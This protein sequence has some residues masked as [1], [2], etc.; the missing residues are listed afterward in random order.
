[1]LQAA[2]GGTGWRLPELLSRVRE[3]DDLYFDAVSQ[4]RL[5]SW[6]TGRVT[7]LGDAAS[8]VSL[9]GEGSSLAMAGA[10]SLA[11]ALAAAPELDVALRR[12]EAEHRKLTGPKQR[13]G[14]Q[15]AAMLIPATRA[16]LAVRN[17]ATRLWPLAAA[18]SWT[19]RKLAREAA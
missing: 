5:P 16:G 7:L 3:A 10:Y 14:S 4:I 13:L 1:L 12:Y 19:G 8:C 15:A 6:S 17:A 18:A 9:F 11:A 2:F